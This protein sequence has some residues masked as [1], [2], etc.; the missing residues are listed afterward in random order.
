MR[1]NLPLVMADLGLGHGALGIVRFAVGAGVV[2]RQD[3]SG[4]PDDGADLVIHL[5][6]LGLLHHLLQRRAGRGVGR[7]F[8]LGD[9]HV[10]MLVEVVMVVCRCADDGA[11][12]ARLGQVDFRVRR[13][14]CRI[15]RADDGADLGLGGCHVDS[16]CRIGDW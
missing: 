14:E 2:R 16:I 1:Y 5:L 9:G 12:L 13:R 7:G 3:G 15:G 10:G 8:V 6:A 4:R 11:F